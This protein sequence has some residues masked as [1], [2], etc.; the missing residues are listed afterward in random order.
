[1]A[2]GPLFLNHSIISLSTGLTIPLTVYL[3]GS[4]VLFCSACWWFFLQFAL[5]KLCAFIVLKKFQERST[6]YSLMLTTQPFFTFLPYKVYQAL[7]FIKLL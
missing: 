7:E 1:M 2:I 4:I 5:K 3:K 6:T